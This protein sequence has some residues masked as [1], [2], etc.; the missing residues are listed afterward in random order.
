MVVGD[1]LVDLIQ[2]L[3]FHI[4]SK[5]HRFIHRIRINSTG[6]Q[7]LAYGLRSGNSYNKQFSTSSRSDS[8]DTA[9]K[10]MIDAGVIF[11]AAAETIIKDL[12]LERMM[13]ID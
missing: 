8:T 7:A 13:L 11:V 12:E 1:I 4:S 3:L 5:E 6:V 10:E 2:E 9:G